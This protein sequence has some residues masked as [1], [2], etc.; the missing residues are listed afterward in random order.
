MTL[1]LLKPVDAKVVRKKV[2][3][4]GDE[5]LRRYSFSEKEI[6]VVKEIISGTKGEI[7]NG[8]YVTEP[9]NLIRGL[10]LFNL[11]RENFPDLSEK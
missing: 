3:E 7:V 1:G 9:V 6:S 2:H 10:D 11:G 5:D 4:L 8:V